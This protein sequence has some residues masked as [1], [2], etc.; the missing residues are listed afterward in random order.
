MQQSPLGCY[1]TSVCQD[2]F[3]VVFYQ[4]TGLYMVTRGNHCTKGI[5]VMSNQIK[6]A[7]LQ[8]III[9]RWR[10]KNGNELKVAANSICCQSAIH[11]EILWL[12]LKF[13]SGTH[14]RVNPQNNKAVVWENTIVIPFL[15]ECERYFLSAYFN[16]TIQLPTSLHQHSRFKLWCWKALLIVSTEL[17]PSNISDK[18]V[19][20]FYFILFQCCFSG[21]CCVLIHIPLK[22]IV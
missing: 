17:E 7:S 16:M 20:I 15:N 1:Y 3:G 2:S 8:S 4:C 6:I 10:E 21:C 9:G 22:Y 19:S 11:L 14:N 12:K 5:S 13:R 18:A